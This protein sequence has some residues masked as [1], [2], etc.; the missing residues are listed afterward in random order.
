MENQEIGWV[1]AILIGGIAGWLAEK[2]TRSNMGLFT[3]IVLG[4]VGA[5]IATWLF[6]LMG[7]RVQAGWL[8]FLISGLA[9]ATLLIVATRMLYPDRW[10]A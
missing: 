6:G 7:I 2:L 8:G 10:R 1:A 5:G 4:V 9:G 3:N